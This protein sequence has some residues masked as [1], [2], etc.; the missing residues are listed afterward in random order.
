MAKN[1]DLIRIEKKRRKRLELK[2]SLENIIRTN[3]PTVITIATAGAGAY[4]G[5]ETHGEVFQYFG[6]LVQTG[7]AYLG[8]HSPDLISNYFN[9]LSKVTIPNYVNKAGDIIGGIG[10]LTS[11]LYNFKKIKEYN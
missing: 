6:D 1:P 9:E 4:I 8:N 11:G 5:F 2:R 10:I 7:L 3:G